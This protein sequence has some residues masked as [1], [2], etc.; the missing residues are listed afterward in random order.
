MKNK[1]N[2]LLLLAVFALL[3]AS[4]YSQ[5]KQVTGIVT[6]AAK[7][8]IPGVNVLVKGTDRGASTDFDGK[9]TVT[10][11]PGETLVFSFVGFVKKEIKVGAVS[12]YNITLEAESSTLNEVT[13]IG[14]G[15][16][17]KKLVTGAISSLK[18]DNFT[19]RPISR[20]DQG[21]I[22]QIAGVRVKQTT[23]LPGQPFSIEIRGAGSI[24]AGNEPLYVI[25]GFP[26]STEGSNAN[27]GFSNGSPLDNI[28]PNDIASFEVLKDA[29]ASSIYGS[30]A[31]NGV[32]LITTKK[33][34]L[35]KTKFTFNTYSGL[36]KEVNRVDM[37]T[38][39]G[40]IKR[41]KTMID[42]QWA[43]SG[44]A[45]ASAG[46]N[47]AQRIATYN[48]ANPTAPL[49]TSNTRY[50]TYLY[51]DRWDMPGHPGLDYIDWQDKVFRTG[52]FS[53]YQFSASGA[54]DVVNYFVSANYQ[55]NT[56]YMVGTDYTLFSGRANLDFKL[57]E[58]FKI[59]I[60]FAP[61][62][63]IK[64]DPGVE[65]KDNTLFKALTATPV[66]ESASNAAGEKYTTRYAWGSS[67]T[68][69]L[70]ALARTGK[71]SMYR[72]LVSSYASFEIANGLIW[73][74]T[75]NLDNTDNTFESYTPNDVQASIRGAYNTYRRQ[76]IV[77]ENTLNFNKSFGSHHF[78]LLL[79]E[80]FSSYKIMRSTLSSGGLYNSSTIETLPTGSLGSTNAEKNTLLSYF[81]RLQYDFK[82]RYLFSAS[83]RS[84]GS[85]KFG[86]DK[87]WGSFYSLSLGWR[88]KQESFLKEVNWLTDLKFRGSV[89]TNGSNNIGSYGSYSTLASYNYSI[90]GAV[91]IGQGVSSIPN[92]SLHW[93]ESKSI[94][95]GVDVSILKN[96]ISATFEVYR[97][98]N[99][100]LLLRVPV[101][102]A[103]GFSSYLTNVG[104][105]QNQG[106]EFE[107]NTLNFTT[108]S[109]EWRTSVNLSHN[110]NKVLALGPDQTKIEISNA[111]DG[112]VP[113]VKLE[114]GKPMYTIFGL[115]QNGVV[116]QAD[117]DNGGT[118]IGGNKL[119]L[120]DPRYI[121]QNGDKKINSEDRV[122]LGNPT[123]KYTWGITNNFKYKDFDLSVLV[124]G[125]NGGTVYGLTGRAIDR[126]GMGSVENSLN[127][128][129]AVRGNWRT[130]F[131]YQANSDWLYKSDYVSIR[132]ISLG[133][134]LKQA[135]KTIKRIDNA[136]LYITGENWFYW[137]KYKVG[138]NP[139]AVNTSGSSNSDFSVPVDYGGAPLA[140]SI[141]L[142]LNIN[143]N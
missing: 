70:N 32:I 29:A 125:Q 46:Q 40:W 2:H 73:K 48:A 94:D 82:E 51:D 6:D 143:F 36:N 35:G 38:S 137:N 30:R 1:I 13:V 79:G 129:P 64:N 8:S 100:E 66:F 95:L 107:L 140:K 99:T 91:A 115:Q 27:G 96:R 71:N 5:N 121:D 42:A 88:V 56:G 135:V 130:S 11:A 53:S 123:P 138:F 106:W 26:I 120:G 61:S 41:A 52:E 55:K 3:H 114:V 23:G 69:M 43:S 15:T 109:F 12:S 19:E 118:T 141:V 54:T 33:G 67:T 58:K 89:G 47:N 112:G 116:T 14:Y 127:V 92:P 98:K 119:V 81:S 17:K 131:G 50:Y 62:Y 9:Y 34:K 111:Y 63:S 22:G 37:L 132:S 83:I 86:S 28:N 90:G 87:R 97:K 65:G 16:Q 68:N 84:D 4:G 122:D 93:E 136:K 72:N 7:L 139:E 10:A 49:T 108:N 75:I 78:N 59:G 133:Y 21:L 102:S 142:G 85:S 126:T 31:A 124:Q 39:E 60:N 44:I 128:D 103:S 105:V 77:N 24:T 101:P 80:S 134:N 18:A 57:S 74:S 45:G 76:N 20:V 104:A 110:E 25:D 113:F 117:I